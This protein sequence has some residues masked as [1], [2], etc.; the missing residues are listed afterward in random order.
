MLYFSF[1]FELSLYIWV[2]YILYNKNIYICRI[3]III[4]CQTGIWEVRW[5]VPALLN[6]PDT[7]SRG[8]VAEYWF[9]EY[10]TNHSECETHD[11][12]LLPTDFRNCLSARFPCPYPLFPASSWNSLFT[13]RPPG[14]VLAW[15]ELLSLY[16][17]AG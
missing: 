12:K 7:F 5:Q 10:D 17:L 16:T 9:L 2:Q 1:Y 13:S 6:L 15:F 14:L 4:W 3:F 8:T 11:N